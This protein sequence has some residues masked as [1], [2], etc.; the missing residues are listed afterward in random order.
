MRLHVESHKL[1]NFLHA[2]LDEHLSRDFDPHEFDR[3]NASILGVVLVD[4]Q[5][6]GPIRKAK[7]IEDG[8][9]SH[10]RTSPLAMQ[11]L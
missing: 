5:A 7:S 11:T 1:T 6:H 10:R 4:V 3:I 8:G 2:A 9:V